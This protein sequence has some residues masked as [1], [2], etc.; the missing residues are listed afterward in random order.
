MK[1]TTIAGRRCLIY[2]EGRAEYVLIQPTGAHEADSLADEYSLI[3]S[4]TD[5]NF[6]LVAVTVDDWNRELSPWSARQAFGDEPF[7]DGAEETLEYIAG[8]LIPA[9]SEY[10]DIAP[11]AKLILGGYSLAGLFSLWCAYR[12]RTDVFSA[13]A[14]CSP[15][16]WLDGWMDFAEAKVPEV[17]NIYLSLGSK[18]HRTRNPMLKTVRDCIIRQNE[19]LCGSGINARLEF[20]PG[21]H[22]QDNSARLAKGFVWC[23][24]NCKN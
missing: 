23:I 21:N 12:N 19:L 15:S 7:G 9:L 11:G 6:A 18:E 20:N 17:R 5:K 14:A 16:V 2:A 24:D 3:K 4:S 1:I 8:K 10:V 13:V 22:F